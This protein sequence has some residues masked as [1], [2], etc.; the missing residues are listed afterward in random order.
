MGV[1]RG[2]PKTAQVDPVTTR[3]D[4]KRPQPDRTQTT[5]DKE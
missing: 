4:K 1:C 5:K 3:K 2:Y